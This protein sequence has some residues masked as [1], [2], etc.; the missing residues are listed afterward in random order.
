MYE[1]L[2]AIAAAIAVFGVFVAGMA[3]RQRRHPD[4]GAGGGCAH[5][6][7]RIRCLGCSSRAGAAAPPPESR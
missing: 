6:S 2:I 4:Q 5:H 1:F 7:G 3:L